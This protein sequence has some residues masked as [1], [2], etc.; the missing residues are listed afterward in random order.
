MPAL[1]DGLLDLLF[2]AQCCHCERWLPSNPGPAR[3]LCERCEATLPWL[4]RGSCVRCQQRQ[5]RPGTDRCGNCENTA[6]GLAS[7]TAA[8]W[9]TGDIEAWIARFKYPRP[10]LPGLDPAPL[11]VARMLACSAA[12]T[13]GCV[14]SGAS[15]GSG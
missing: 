7:C 10:G 5:P 12:N 11:A 2:P 4:D 1:L 8:A 14:P 9:Y 15:T 6:Y 3:A 13:S